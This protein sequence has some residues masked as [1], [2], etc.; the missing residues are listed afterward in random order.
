M[1][2]EALRSVRLVIG[3][4]FCWST[5]QAATI[6]IAFGELE[7]FSQVQSPRAKIINQQFE[8]TLAD[9]DDRL[10][11]SNP[12]LAYARENVDVLD[13][14]QITIGKQFEV[15]WAYL[16]KKSSWKDNWERLFNKYCT[17]SYKINKNLTKTNTKGFYK[18]TTCKSFNPKSKC[19]W[20]KGYS[21]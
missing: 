21:T 9:R 5:V 15:P 19:C 16:K 8:R 3:L 7:D 14:Y 18:K 2:V 4:G 11:W 6:P 17:T 20:C 13:E 1:L 10:K 12:E